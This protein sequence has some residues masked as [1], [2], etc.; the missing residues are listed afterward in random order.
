MTV[1]APATGIVFAT[2]TQ[3]DGSQIPLQKGAGAIV[4]DGSANAPVVGSLGTLLT[5][6]AVNANRRGAIV[7]NQSVTQAY[8][9]LDD[10]A[11]GTITVFSLDP[12]IGVGRQGG[13]WDTTPL[14]HTGRIRVYGTAGAQIGAAQN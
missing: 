12:A 14:L 9:V 2:E 10:G 3:A 11:S 13:S 6:I 4:T 5:T 1:T 8:V 7:Q